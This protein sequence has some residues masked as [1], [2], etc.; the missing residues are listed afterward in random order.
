[1]NMESHK[2]FALAIIFTASVFLLAAVSMAAEQKMYVVGVNNNNDTLEIQDITVT[3]EN[4]VEEKPFDEASSYVIELVS[5]NNAVL[6]KAKFNFALIYE[7]KEIT[8][9]YFSNG[10]EIRVYDKDGNIALNESVMQFAQT[11]GDKICQGHESYESCNT[12]CTSGG[13][14]DY[15]DS[16]S[17]GICDPDCRAGQDADCVAGNGLQQVA[18]LIAAA[19]S[20]VIGILYV[21][22]NREK[23]V[24]KILKK[25][26]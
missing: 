15:C 16:V 6:Y 8:I 10:K 3:I 5:T 12:D 21:R 1:M 11:C 4:L 14:D 2:F 9:P 18:V 23:A 19:G 7:Y 13:K 24:E 22:R 26:Q 17:D 20:V 25:L